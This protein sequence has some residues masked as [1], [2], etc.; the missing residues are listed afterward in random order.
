[1]M[2]I[3]SPLLSI[4]SLWPMGIPISQSP[5]EILASLFAIQEYKIR[6]YIEIGVHRGGLASLLLARRIFQPDFNYFG[7]EI[8]REILDPSLFDVAKL[9]DEIVIEDFFS[10]D[11]HRWFVNR[12]YG[13]SAPVLV[14]CDGGNKRREMKEVTP[15]LRR[16]DFMMAHDYKKE[17]FDE[18]IPDGLERL[19]PGWLKNCRLALMRK[20]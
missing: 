5:R 14:L 13:H 3:K 1:M 8:D 20:L 16:G 2:I 7:I 19:C 6:T 12:L 9:G 4:G 17:F 11:G 15:V 18:D 10:E